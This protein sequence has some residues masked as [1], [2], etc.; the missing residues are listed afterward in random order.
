MIANSRYRGFRC[1]L[2]ECRRLFQVDKV[3][4]ADSGHE[5]RCECG[6]VWEWDGE[7]MRIKQKPAPTRVPA[8]SR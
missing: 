1:S 7:R 8:R 2:K 5:H 4:L 6:A 3:L